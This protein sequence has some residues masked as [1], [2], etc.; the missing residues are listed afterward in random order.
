MKQHAST[1]LTDSTARLSSCVAE[2]LVAVHGG[3]IQCKLIVHV[4]SKAASSTS[5]VTAFASV[6]PAVLDASV[7]TCSNV[8]IVMASC[9]TDAALSE[10]SLASQFVD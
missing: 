7:L 4:N 9:T 2:T 3:K 1:V 10:P 8:G 5:A 6:E